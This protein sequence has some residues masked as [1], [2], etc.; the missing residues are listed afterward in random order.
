MTKAGTFNFRSWNA[1]DI[2]RA[3]EMWWAGC[4]ASTIAAVLSTTLTA[5]TCKAV[6]EGWTRDPRS[7]HLFVQRRDG[8]ATELRHKRGEPKPLRK[9]DGTHYTLRDA[10]DSQCRWIAGPPVIDAPICGHRVAVKGKSW[11]AFHH[12]RVFPRAA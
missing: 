12:A 1:A 2:K 8:C 4:E 5:V 7:L 11:C 10:A 3:K 6:N 9:P